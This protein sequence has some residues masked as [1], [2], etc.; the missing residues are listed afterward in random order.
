MLKLNFLWLSRLISPRIFIL[1]FISG[2][3]VCSLLGRKLAHD[4]YYQNYVRVSGPYQIDNTFLLSPS[5]ITTLIK[6]ECS[7]DKILVLVGGSS[8]MSGVGQPDRYLWSKKLKELLGEGYCVY[9]LAGRAGLMNG[10]ASTTL[11]IIANSYKKAYLLSDMLEPFAEANPDG[12]MSQKHYFWDAYY[13]NMLYPPFERKVHEK[14]KQIQKEVSTM[15]EKD[16][17]RL[18]QVKIGEWLDSV[19]YF[20]ELWT[21]FHYNFISAFY[22][23]RFSGSYQWAPRRT[24]PENDAEVNYD[25]LHKLKQYSQAVNSLE[26]QKTLEKYQNIHNSYFNFTSDGFKLSESYIARFE[27]GIKNSFLTGMRQNVL[28]AYIGISPYY[29]DHFTKQEQVALEALYTRKAAVVKKYGYDVV[30]PQFGAEDFIDPLHLNT[31][32]GFKLAQVIADS[33]KLYDSN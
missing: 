2:L 16:Q 18:E 11:E 26:F 31:L 3:L 30:R 24:W 23:S 8:V 5:Q 1:G 19:F 33:I 27:E 25:D 10:F 28:L 20:N 4:G 32:G 22:G 14:A 15:S 21:Y 7:N 6:K 17:E 9:N 13:K 29:S 12:A